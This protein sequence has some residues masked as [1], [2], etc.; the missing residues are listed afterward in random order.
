MRIYVH[1]ADTSVIHQ[2][3][4]SGIVHGITT[5]PTLLRRTG[6][7][8]RQVP[9]LVSQM[10]GWG[11]REIHFQ[12]YSDTVKGMVQEGQELYEMAQDRMVVRVPATPTGYSAAARLSQQGVP[13]SLTVV[14][15]LRQAMLAAN[16]GARYI[17]VFVRRMNDSG[18]DGLARIGKIQDIVK[19]QELPVTIIAASMREPVGTVERLAMMGIG[20]A[21]LTVSVFEELLESPA[22]E[23]DMLDFKA[24]AEAVLNQSFEVGSE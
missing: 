11:A 9:A 22:T 5:N 12:V 1:T 16:V 24:D 4:S 18:I 23:R 14:Y 13:V 20:G 7:S 3:L 21:T 19:A 10:A 2:A 8:A 6:I 17:A 15:T